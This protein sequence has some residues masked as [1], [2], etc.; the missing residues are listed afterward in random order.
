[1]NSAETKKRTRGQHSK[2]LG[3]VSIISQKDHNYIWKFLHLKLHR[4]LHYK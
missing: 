3:K 1:M 4:L 2:D